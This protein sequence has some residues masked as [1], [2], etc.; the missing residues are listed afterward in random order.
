MVNIL[1]EVAESL[2]LRELERQISNRYSKDY[3]G[4]GRSGR[5][6]KHGLGQEGKVDCEDG[7]R[8]RFATRNTWNKL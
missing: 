5:A 3:G 6:H 1:H 4:V 7:T 2:Y 8:S